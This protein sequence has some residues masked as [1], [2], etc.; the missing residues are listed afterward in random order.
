MLPFTT[1]GTSNVIALNSARGYR[2]SSFANHPID[3]L[4][5]MGFDPTF[6]DHQFLVI[7]RGTK[8][9]S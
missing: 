6:F 7:C 1:A 4:D 8:I 9:A 5:F 3:A 2:V